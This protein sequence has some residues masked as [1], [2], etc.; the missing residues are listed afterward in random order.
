MGV[1]DE[2]ERFEPGSLEDWSAWLAEHHATTPGVW[3]VS[4]KKSS[5]RQVYDYDEAVVE[6]LRWG[7]VDSTQRGVDEHRSMM[8]F[9]PRRPQSVWTRNNKERIARLEAEG[10]L[11][12][13]GRAQVEAARADGRWTQMDD[14]EDL[15]VPPDLAEAFAAHPG[16]REQYDAFRPSVRKQILAWIVLAKRPETRGVRVETTAEKAARGE[17]SQP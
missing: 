5:G 4:A 7:W 12:P 10:R 1:M 13:A 3:L 11:E 14:V 16:S 9:A 17:K 2:A 8:W 6:A 15:V